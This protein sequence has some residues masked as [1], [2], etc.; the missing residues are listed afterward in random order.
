MDTL[1]EFALSHPQ[2]FAA[3]AV[4]GGDSLTYG[5]LDR[6]SAKLARHLISLGLDA[7]EAVAILMGNTLRYFE[8]AWAA[9]RAGLFYVPISSHLNSAEASYIIEDSGAKVIFVSKSLVDLI[10]AMEPSLRDKLKVVV[11]DDRPTFSSSSSYAAIV[12]SDGFPSD[13]P[14]RP[15]GMDF[16]Y[17]SGTTGRPKGIKPKILGPAQLKQLLAA[18]WLKFLKLTPEAVYLSPAP[19]YHAAPLRFSMRCIMAGGTVL[20]MSKFDARR[21][22]EVIEQYRVTHSQ[23]VPTMFA[24]ML[25]LPQE[26]RDAF[27]HSC[28]Q[29]ALHAAAPCPK[30]V[31]LKMMEWWGPI[32]WE[33]YSGSE[34][35]GATVISPDEWIAHQGSVGR[36]ASGEIRIV[37][38]DGSMC[39]P[40]KEGLVYFAN[41][42]AFEYH[43]DPTKTAEAFNEQGW[44]T[45]G[46]IGYVDEEGFLYLTDR[47]SNMIISGG[48]NIYPQEAENV[49]QAHPAV[50]DVAVFGT[51]H[52]DFGE[53]VVAVVQLSEGCAESE[54]L[55]QELI[56]FCRSQLAHFKCPRKVDFVK[57]LPR[58]ETGKLLKRVAR[59]QYRARLL[60]I[61]A[62]N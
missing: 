14:D 30:D 26:V 12:E 25:A 5:D 56:D 48:V 28:M 15:V 23:W 4:D 58:T 53:Q 2:K 33:Y 17:S 50:A 41:G 35:N 36:A 19:L 49:L 60:A 46:D 45:I 61:E 29:I 62:K 16:A 57:D 32:I 18:D 31:K 24:R 22:L 8:V 11:V 7:G 3:R 34:R 42:P 54:A 20:V 59:D 51:P 6:R 13:L 1:R 43:N 37:G 21:A 39:S 47:R 40:R 44:S 27:D 52:P 55:A 38:E 10:D 9:R